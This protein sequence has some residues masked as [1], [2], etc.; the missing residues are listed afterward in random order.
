MQGFVI[1]PRRLSL[2]Q[3]IHGQLSLPSGFDQKP[4]YQSGSVRIV[5]ARSAHL[6]QRPVSEPSPVPRPSFRWEWKLACPKG[7]LGLA[8]PNGKGNVEFH[9]NVIQRW[10]AQIDAGVFTQTADEAGNVAVSAKYTGLH[11]LRHFYASWCINR[12]ADGGLELPPKV[13]QDRLGHSSITVTMDTYGHLF[14]RSDDSAELA[15][16]EAALLSTN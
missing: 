15:A 11:A 8:F 12:K 6:R 2:F 14:P 16:A 13:V 4:A 9:V 3:Y 5:I 7:S 10:P 1:T